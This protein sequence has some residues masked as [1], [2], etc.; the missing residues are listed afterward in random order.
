MLRLMKADWVVNAVGGTLGLMEA[1]ALVIVGWSAE[2]GSGERTTNEVSCIA[3][4]A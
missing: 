3:L 1:I 4:S 2:S